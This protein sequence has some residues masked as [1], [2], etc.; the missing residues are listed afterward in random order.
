MDAQTSPSLQ[1]PLE[2]YLEPIES[3]LKVMIRT[4][5]FEL[6]VAIRKAEAAEDDVEAHEYIVEFSGPDSDLLVEKHATLLDALEY[7]VLKAVRL[8]EEHF[9]KISFDCGDWRRMRAEELKLTARMAAERVIETG[10][11]FTLNPMNPRERRIVHLALRDQP[12]VLT[13]SEGFGPERK[14]VIRPASPPRRS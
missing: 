9:G 12:Q 14:V 3:L 7:V 13:A 2:S 10:D 11:P 1:R 8:E 6:K 4:G 5:H